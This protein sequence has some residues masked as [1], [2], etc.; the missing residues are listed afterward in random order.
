MESLLGFFG[1]MG[2]QFLLVVFY[3]GILL[4]AKHLVVSLFM[5]KPAK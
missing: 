4:L 2:M 3:V 5:R 1:V